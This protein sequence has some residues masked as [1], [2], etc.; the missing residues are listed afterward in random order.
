MTTIAEK[1]YNLKSEKSV[2]AMGSTSER[3]SLSRTNRLSSMGN[4]YLLIMEKNLVKEDGI[5]M[6]WK[7]FGLSPKSVF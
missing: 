5:L 3:I 2:Q 1:H 4:I 7:A 6:D